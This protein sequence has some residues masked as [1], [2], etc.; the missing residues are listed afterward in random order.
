MAMADRAG[1]F[2]GEPVEWGVDETG[3]KGLA[4]FVCRF[5]LNEWF[6]QA[7]GGW[8]EWSV[9]DHAI[10]GY[11]Y[12]EKKDGSPNETGIRQIKEALGWDGLDVRWLQQADLRGVGVQLELGWEEYEGQNRLRI[13]WL[14]P[15]D[16]EGSRVQRA[17]DAG[18]AAIQGR[19]G[20]KLRALAV[21]AA[22]GTPAPAQVSPSGTAATPAP[23]RSAPAGGQAPS[24]P[25]S[26]PAA[27]PA[28]AAKAT[29]A[30]TATKSMAWNRLNET[31]G[32]T[33]SVAEL[34]QY[35]HTCIRD[36]GKP[37]AAF[38]SEDWAKLIG[39]IEVPF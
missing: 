10:T 26:P 20:G 31:W 18:L 9:Y 15:L 16:W 4:T 38:G 11:F 6:D 12:L 3:Q 37:E 25:Q 35:W 7:G 23:A 8:L 28:P 5:R 21:P 24:P 27:P 39:L 14:N 32:E 29:A 34:E 1:T 30:P 22:A 2:K 19:L 17:D 13:K 33:K 36:L